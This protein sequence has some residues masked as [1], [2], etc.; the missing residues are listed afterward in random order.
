VS[1]YREAGEA[2]CHQCDRPAREDCTACSRRTCAKHLDARSMCG[3]C[4]EAHYRYMRS[5]DGAGIW[6]G[7]PVSLL[8]AA[9]LGLAVPVLLPLAVALPFVGFP[10]LLYTRKRRRHARFFRMMR[11]RGALPQPKPELTDDDI[12]RARFEA[13]LD[14]RMYERDTTKS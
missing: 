11:E 12:E 10:V 4:D 1:A 13:S 9:V 2:P 8:V 6:L 7:L 5:D 14:N 3:K